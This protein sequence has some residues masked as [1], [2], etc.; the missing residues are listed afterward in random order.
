MIFHI[1]S[2]KTFVNLKFLLQWYVWCNKAA[3]PIQRGKR[4][5]FFFVLRKKV[6]FIQINGSV[7]FIRLHFFHLLS[8]SVYELRACWEMWDTII[9]QNTLEEEWESA[10]VWVCFLTQKVQACKNHPSI[11]L[12]LRLVIICPYV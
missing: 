10:T 5:F 4:A 3:L 8:S 11:F 1:S 7:Y 9:H 6:F 2:S 12:V